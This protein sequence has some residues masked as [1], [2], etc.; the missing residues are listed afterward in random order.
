MNDKIWISSSLLAL[1]MIMAG[2]VGAG[3][4]GY[5]AMAG[6]ETVVPFDIESGMPV[7]PSISLAPD[8]TDPYDVT[9]HPYLPEVWI[10]GNEGVLILDRATGAELASLDLSA[11]DSYLVDI[12]FNP[13][14]DTAYI[15]DRNENELVLVDVGTHAP[16]GETINL[17]SGFAPGWLAVH[18]VT[19]DIYVTE[20]QANDI[21]HI[22]G[23]T[24][25]PVIALFPGGFR[26]RD[27]VFSPDLDILYIANG[28]GNDEI[29]FL[30]VPEFD[31]LEQVP[32]GEDPW[33]V[34]VTPDGGKLFSANQD[35]RDVSVVDTVSLSVDTI[36]LT[37]SAD[38]R[39]VAIAADGS[40]VYVPTGGISGDDGVFVIDPDTHALIETFGFGAEDS[41]SN[42]LAVAPKTVGD[43]LFID[44][45]ESR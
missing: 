12:A 26:L 38:P 23:D 24:L 39:D 5:V 30:D 7:L 16:T 34:T 31:I 17:G 6:S 15:S 25:V 3:P 29:L 14:G 8:A 27:L 9:I 10:A 35:S 32:V 28:V 36:D 13:A 11:G 20:W 22:D 33:A 1:G 21:A 40:A 45:F 4:M 19:G 2:P 37:P 43:F 44:G 41:F 18:P 42:V